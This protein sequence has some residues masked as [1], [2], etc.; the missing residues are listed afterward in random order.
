M[1]NHCVG[2]RPALSLAEARVTQL[3]TASF[4]DKLALK[5]LLQDLC[6]RPL[7]K[8]SATD[9]YAM[10]LY[11]VSIRGV[12]SRSLQ[13][14]FYAMSL[15]MASIRGVLA[16]SLYKIFTRGL[17]ARSLQGASGQDLNRS[18]CNVCV[19][20]LFMKPLHKAL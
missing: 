5:A 9:P 18:L 19:Q 6:K 3:A 14:D 12:L 8:I 13:P 4:R 17:L 16:R 10:S 11:K 1:K 20:D 15:C 2:L 7:G